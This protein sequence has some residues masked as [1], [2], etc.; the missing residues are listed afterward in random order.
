MPGSTRRERGRLA[1]RGRG[2][3]DRGDRRDV[4]PHG[5]QTRARGLAR[6]HGDGRVRPVT[7]ATRPVRAPVDTLP[8]GPRGARDAAWR[9]VP[10]AWRDEFRGPVRVPGEGALRRARR[11]RAAGGG[12]RH[13]RGGEGR[14]RQ[15]RHRRRGEGPGEDRWPGQGRRRQAGQRRRRGGGE[16]DRDPRPGH[17]G[18]R[19]PPGA[20]H[21]GQ[22]HRHRVLRVVPAGPGQPDLP[23][24]GLGRGRDGD[25]AARGR[26]A[27]GAGPGPGRP[28][29]RVDAAKAARSPTPP[30]SRPTCGTR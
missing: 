22:R 18:P 30:A 23:G 4:D 14:R 17:Q 3:R 9:V 5:A 25:R 13:R 11:A 26:A 2:V 7:D 29:R 16:G 10:S 8:A 21:R 6:S 27:G 24:D 1:R 15:D 12:G 28:D 19:G 20:R